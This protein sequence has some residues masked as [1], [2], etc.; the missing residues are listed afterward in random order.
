MKIATLGKAITHYGIPT[1]IQCQD[2]LT[3][4]Y[5]ANKTY[6]WRKGNLNWKDTVRGIVRSL[7]KDP[8][9]QYQRTSLGEQTLYHF[10]ADNLKPGT[11]ANRYELGGYEF[12]IV[13]FNF[14]LVIEHQSAY[15]NYD[16]ALQQ[17]QDRLTY[18]EANNINILY[19]SD[20]FDMSQMLMNHGLSGEKSSSICVHYKSNISSYTTYELYKKNV[21]PQV[22]DCMEGNNHEFLSSL[23][24]QNQL[25]PEEFKQAYIDSGNIARPGEATMADTV[26]EYVSIMR[27]MTDR[28]GLPPNLIRRTDQHRFFITNR[29]RPSQPKG[30]TR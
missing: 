7:S 14:N 28:N 23:L 22:L 20:N 8:S 11:V 26:P 27:S 12:D 15:H 10:L 30:V 6:K 18:L 2:D 16:K 24:K 19:V 1:D 13:L 17:D 4:E 3:R 25:T 9:K 21:I 29:F 5:K